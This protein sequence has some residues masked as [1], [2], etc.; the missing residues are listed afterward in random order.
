MHGAA[1]SEILLEALQEVVTAK[2][3]LDQPSAF[4]CRLLPVC[5][6]TPAEPCRKLVEA[7]QAAGYPISI[8]VYPGDHHAFDSDRPVRY[9]A[10]R[11]NANSPTGRGATTGGDRQAWADSINEI[12]SFFG[13]NLKQNQK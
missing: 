5:A 2:K 13:K 7:A 11:V 6:W 10:Q 9:V 1:Q 3:A 12:D 8:K 4:F